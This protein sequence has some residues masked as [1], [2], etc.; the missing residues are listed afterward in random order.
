MNINELVRSKMQLILNTTFRDLEDKV[1]CK[2]ENAFL[3]FTLYNCL[4]E[5]LIQHCSV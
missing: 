4:E 5:D 1:L 3:S 2:V